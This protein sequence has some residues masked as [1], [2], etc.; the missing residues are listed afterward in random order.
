MGTAISLQ[1]SDPLPESRLH[2][3]AD[4]VF[5]WLRAV[6]RRFSTYLEDSEVNRFDRGSCRSASAP[7][8]CAR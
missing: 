4:D 6:D 3:L 5:D 7:P 1:I 2:E 8:T